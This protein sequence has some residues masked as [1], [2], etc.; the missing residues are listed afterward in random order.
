MFI[1]GNTKNESLSESVVCNQSNQAQNKRVFQTFP[2]A[3]RFLLFI[4][5]YLILLSNGIINAQEPYGYYYKGEFISL[6]ASRR[7]VAI[8]E[9]GTG[10]SNFVA[11][12]ELKRDPLA[13]QEPLKSRKLGLYR[14]PPGAPAEFTN[15]I[16]QIEEFLMTTGEEVQPVFEQG[17]ALLIPSNEI[18]AGFKKETS[19]D[20]AQSYFTKCCQDQGIIDLI[21]HRTNSFILTINNPSN[22]RVYQVCQVLAGLDEIRFA[23]P[24]HIIVSL[25]LPVLPEFPEEMEFHP[26]G[27]IQRKEVPVHNSPVTWTDL[28]NEDFEG[29]TLPAGWGTG[30]F[31]NTYVEAYW[32]VTNYRSHSGNQSCY[33]T[34]VGP[35]GVVPPGDYPVNVYNWLETPTLNLA[36][37]EEVYIE[38]W[39]YAKFDGALSDRAI[40]TIEDPATGPI[41]LINYIYSEYTGD[42][43]ADPTT[44]NG[45]RRALFRVPPL[46]RQD[47]INVRISFRSFDSGTA[48][49]L[50]I[51]QVRITGTLNVDT[52]PIGNDTYGARHYEMKNSGQIAGLG[53]D[54]NDMEVPEAWDLVQVSPN[55]VV[56]VIDSGVYLTHPD[57][58]LIT[59]YDPDGSIG[60]GHRHA[61][62]TAVAGNVG[63][64]KDNNIGVFGTAPGVKIMPVYK[65]GVSGGVAN[66][67]DVAVANGAHILT[68]SWGW[69]GSPSQEI[70]DAIIDALNAG[71]IVL[72]AA[73]NGPDRPPYTYEVAFP[74][75]LNGFTDVIAV[76]ACSPTDEHKAAA[77]SDG[78]FNWGSSYVGDGP[79]VVAPGP[80]SYS[81]DIPGV[82]G[83]NGSRIDPD[84]PGSEDY[85]PTFGGTSSATPKVAGIVALLLSAHPTLTPQQ[86]KQILRDTADD[87]DAPGFDDK[88]GAGR[89][90]AYEAVKAVLPPQDLG[91]HTGV[92]L[93]AGVVVPIGGLANTTD[94][95]F[96]IN[97][98]FVY[99]FTQYLALDIRC[100]YS[101]L[102]GTGTT[103][104]VH[105]LNLSVNVKYVYL[106][107]SPWFFINA[108]PGLYYI[109]WND[110]R[111]GVNLGAGAGWPLGSLLD[112]ELTVNYHR[113]FTGS[114]TLEFV[115]G[116]LGIIL[117]F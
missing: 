58:N 38:L 3:V 13:D 26:V 28:I 73:G 50:Y 43:T 92:S 72:F 15:I 77:S 71:R 90:N 67:I 45:W 24:N 111:G 95:G 91:L 39:F 83:Y 21:E 57:L 35:D 116:Q 102:F 25:Y 27:N 66:A 65:G 107:S 93:H 98:D 30:R 110:L 86:V 109:D 4:L 18:L 33:A 16:I 82:A 46:L 60:G 76:G 19:L 29:T 42:M 115:K 100:G 31:N 22:G 68:N 89:V 74:A 51:D 48:E 79:D 70:E 84:D 8:S 11:E 52:E 10:Y 101:L 75:S 14:I 87:I 6:A 1:K 55:I 78:S 103:D 80:W 53:N 96:S 106:M 105:I 23:E 114:P 44:D 56:A 81:T 37:Y 41:G 112:M 12:Q 63:A 47:G 94:P 32:D 61:H 9:K 54:N 113:T 40:I 2:Q 34:G 59:G 7:F 69:V 104:D 62:G 17:Q 85:T 97:I 108:G 36:G 20:D 88:T 117:K 5:L 64:I 99:A 49:G